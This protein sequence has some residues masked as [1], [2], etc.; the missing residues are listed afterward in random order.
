[1]G[2]G[3]SY[4]QLPNS[5]TR[6]N[7]ALLEKINDLDDL[8]LQFDTSDA[9]RRFGEAWKQARVIVDVGG[10]RSTPPATPTPVPAPVA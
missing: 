3:I 7:S 2:F 9:G 4:N 5:Q 8:V 10:G 6:P 1:M